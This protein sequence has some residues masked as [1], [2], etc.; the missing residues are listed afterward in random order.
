MKR[1]L[2]QSAFTIIESMIYISIAAI[3]LSAL[4]NF[5]WQIIYANIKA[6]AIREVQQNSR[7]AMEKIFETILSAND[8]IVPANQGESGALL[9]LEMDDGSLSPT[10]IELSN[11]KLLITQGFNGPYEITSSEVEVLSLIFTNA[12]Y[13]AEKETVRV[14]MS[15]KS[16]NQSQLIYYDASLDSE[17]TISLRK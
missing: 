8:I 10:S 2:G 7:F 5:A 1:K 12:S 13:S 11:G 9:S 17:G 16:K 15:I 3:V 6:Q 4:F 14:Q